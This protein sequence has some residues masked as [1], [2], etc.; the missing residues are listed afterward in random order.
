MKNIAKIPLKSTV[1]PPD[2]HIFT[3]VATADDDVEAE[4]LKDLLAALPIVL[5]PP[6]PVGPL[7]TVPVAVSVMLPGLDS[8]PDPDR[9]KDESE[10]EPPRPAAV[11]A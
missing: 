9:D 7:P 3:E 4:A 6:I 11:E 10:E 5:D 1:T 2:K 8:D